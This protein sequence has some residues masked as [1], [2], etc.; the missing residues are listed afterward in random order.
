MY[1]LYILNVGKNKDLIINL[2]NKNKGKAVKRKYSVE[3]R[4]FALTLHFYSPKAYNFVRNN[5]NSVLPHARTLSKWYSHVDADPG[6]TQESLNILT[7]KINNSVKPIYCA[8]MI[9][10]VA[11][12]KH[13]E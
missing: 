1:N 2:A 7:L 6:F 13:V 9:D 5:F 3:L 12:R 8:L 11:I 4:K 10:E